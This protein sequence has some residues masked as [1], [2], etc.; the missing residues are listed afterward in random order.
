MRFDSQSSRE[1]ERSDR[2]YCDRT[3]DWMN[4][5]LFMAIQTF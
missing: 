2:E 4:D 1:P 5:F 3:G